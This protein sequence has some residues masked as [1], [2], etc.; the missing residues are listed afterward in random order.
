M[1]L[2]TD[3]AVRRVSVA[4]LLQ[5]SGAQETSR[6]TAPRAP[7]IRREN[8]VSIR[9]RGPLS[10]GTLPH[11]KRRDRHEERRESLGNRFLDATFLLAAMSAA[12][13]IL[14]TTL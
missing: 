10:A 11:A 2:T 9:T 3:G 14:W 12:A 5:N 13:L 1:F 4:E 7:Q 8:V 6:R